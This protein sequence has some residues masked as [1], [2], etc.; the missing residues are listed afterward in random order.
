MTRWVWGLALMLALFAGVTALSRPAGADSPIPSLDNPGP[1]GLQV[2]ATWLREAGAQIEPHDRP[3]TELPP[4]TRVVLIAAPEQEE[5]QPAEVE[6]LQAFVAEGGTLVYLAPRLRVQPAMNHWLGIVPGK[7]LRAT[8]DGFARHDVGGVSVDIE[9]PGGPLT[10]LR[11]L[12]LSADSTVELHREEAVPVTTK[13]ALWWLKE[14]RGEVWVAAGPDLAQN[15]RLELGDN[16]AFWS[17]L[18]A[19][20]P[21][22]VD[23]YHHHVGASRVPWS[24]T[25][26]VLQLIFVA[27]IYVWVSAPRFGPPRDPPQTRVPSSL[28]A[29]RAMST[30]YAQ[31]KV[32]D[33]LT[34]SARDQF[35]RKIAESFGIPRSWSWAEVAQE[36]ARR[37]GRPLQS[38]TSLERESRFLELSRALAELEAALTDP[39]TAPIRAAKSST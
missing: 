32:D 36:L 10:G 16:A 20:G 34:A 15:A 21:M 26:A 8:G 33:E 19:K 11:S 12:R 23:E 13:N 37:T 6:R 4:E 22:R 27:L 17:R 38:L 3:L 5:L 1:L 24:L 2:M 28:E 25:A 9:L 39:S 35:R 14:G 29:V 30:L 31:A 18:S 7:S